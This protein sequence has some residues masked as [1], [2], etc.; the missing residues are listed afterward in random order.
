MPDWDLLITDANIATMR[1]GASAYG[2]M[3]RAALA[4]AAGRIAWIGP[5]SELPAHRAAETRSIHGRWLSLM[6]YFASPE[7][8]SIRSY[9]FAEYFHSEYGARSGWYAIGDG[10]FKLINMRDRRELYNLRVDLSESNDLLADSISAAEQE[11][12]DRLT[13]I[14]EDLRRSE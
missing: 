13:A 12:A 14:V 2:A 8:V 1:S 4:V 7:T 11:T 10:D 6:P 5:M 9:Q 3:E